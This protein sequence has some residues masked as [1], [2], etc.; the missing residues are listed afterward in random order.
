[1]VLRESPRLRGDLGV[2]R[3]VGEQLEHLALS[4][5]EA[6]R[7]GAWLGFGRRGKCEDVEC[8]PGPEDRAA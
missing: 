6:T 3:A 7:I 1:M 5:R 2:A 4:I 8:D